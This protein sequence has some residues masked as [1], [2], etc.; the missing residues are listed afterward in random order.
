MG[1]I[2]LRRV[3]RGLEKGGILAPRPHELI[4]AT[5]PGWAASKWGGGWHTPYLP[6]RRPPHY[7][8]T[9]ASLPA[10]YCHPERLELQAQRTRWPG[11]RAAAHRAPVPA[12]PN[13]PAAPPPC[14]WFPAQRT[15]Y[16]PGLALKVLWGLLRGRGRA[17]LSWCMRGWCKDL[18]SVQ[19]R[20]LRSFQTYRV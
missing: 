12:P 14:L 17:V 20:G 11:P 13:P 19:T 16:S 9:L 3:L 6:W 10:W 4:V 18:G 1:T 2:L 15:D 5:A 8:S 7:Y